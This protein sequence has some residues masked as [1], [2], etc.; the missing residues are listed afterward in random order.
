MEIHINFTL[1]IVYIQ[2]WLAFASGCLIT[3][4]LCKAG[5]E[6]GYDNR[7]ADFYAAVGLIVALFAA[8]IGT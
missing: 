7:M 6:P 1:P 8:A 5:T 2:C 4:A 3:L